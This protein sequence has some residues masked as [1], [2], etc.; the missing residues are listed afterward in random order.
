MIDEESARLVQRYTDSAAAGLESISNFVYEGSNDPYWFR[1][2]LLLLKPNIRIFLSNV[3]IASMIV[4]LLVYHMK[5]N[6]QILLFPLLF[7]IIIQLCGLIIYNKYGIYLNAEAAK[8]TVYCNEIFEILIKSTLLV[9]LYLN[10][11]RPDAVYMTAELVLICMLAFTACR[12]SYIGLFESCLNFPHALTLILLLA[13]SNKTAPMSFQV[14]FLPL[15]I[16]GVIMM[17]GFLLAACCFEY[18]LTFANVC[19]AFQYEADF[20]WLCNNIVSAHLWN[21]ILL[22]DVLH[23]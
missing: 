2:N 4:S 22:P 7:E 18:C 3:I 15:L 13:R 12:T 8:C 9:V 6:I 16:L 21:G 14:A 23:R 1:K 20:C 10:T 17:F 11:K 19:A 5:R